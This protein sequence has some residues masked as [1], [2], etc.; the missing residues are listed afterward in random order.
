VVSAETT[1][2]LKIKVE[3]LEAKLSVKFA[4]AAAI[5]TTWAPDGKRAQVLVRLGP[6]ETARSEPTLSA[7]PLPGDKRSSSPEAPRTRL[8]WFSHAM[9][10]LVGKTR[11]PARVRATPRE[12]ALAGPE[13][14]VQ[15]AESKGVLPPISRSAPAHEQVQPVAKSLQTR[16]DKGWSLPK[17]PAQAPAS[18][19][20]DAAQ[21]HPEA[22]ALKLPELQTSR[23]T[24]SE[25][26]ESP[27]THAAVLRR[28]R[29]MRQGK[30]RQEWPREDWGRAWDDSITQ[31]ALRLLATKSESPDLT[32]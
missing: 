5:R 27:L 24:R 31:T 16:A 7:K 13:V 11:D 9:G 15:T 23:T 17:L 4:H 6:K 8:R 29:E 10:R 1:E 32:T 20:M 30:P 14:R 21:P 2:E 19:Q 12:A 18:V 25:P 22:L 26:V 28:G 3:G